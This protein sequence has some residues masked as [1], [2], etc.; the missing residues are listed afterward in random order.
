[1]D[2]DYLTLCT[3]VVQEVEFPTGYIP[4]KLVRLAL[5]TKESFTQQHITESI[6][7]DYD[8]KNK[9]SL[10]IIEILNKIQRKAYYLENL[11]KVSMTKIAEACSNVSIRK[12]YPSLE[13][14]LA[15]A[16]EL[17][18]MGNAS[19][20]FPYFLNE[21]EVSITKEAASLMTSYWRQRH[22]LDGKQI[23]SIC[24]VLNQIQDIILSL[25]ISNNTFNSPVKIINQTESAMM[26]STN[27]IGTVV[28]SYVSPSP[29]EQQAT[30]ETVDIDR[31]AYRRDNSAALITTS[32]VSI[33]KERM[34]FHLEESDQY[35]D[36]SSKIGEV[37]RKLFPEE[38]SHADK[39]IPIDETTK[40]KPLLR[41]NPV[42][43]KMQFIKLMK[44]QLNNKQIRDCKYA[45]VNGLKYINNS[46]S[47][48]SLLLNDEKLSNNQIF[49][50]GLASLPNSSKA[51]HI[52]DAETI[53]N[54]RNNFSSFVCESIGDKD[55]GVLVF[56]DRESH[57][58]AQTYLLD[59]SRTPVFCPTLG[60]PDKNSEILDTPIDANDKFLFIYVIESDCHLVAYL[61]KWFINSRSTNKCLPIVYVLPTLQAGIGN[62]RYLI[63]QFAE[64]KLINHEW[65]YM[66][67]DSVGAIFTK[68]SKREN[69]C[70][71]ITL[72][73]ALELLK[74]RA[75]EFATSTDNEVTVIGTVKATSARP[76]CVDCYFP[77]FRFPSS[78]ILLNVRVC[79]KYSLY[80]DPL[81]RV[82]ED[83]CFSMRSVFKN[84]LVLVDKHFA[85][86]KKQFHSGGSTNDKFMKVKNT[87]STF[88]APPSFA[89]TFENA[90]SSESIQLREEQVQAYFPDEFDNISRKC[91]VVSSD[92][93]LWFS[94]FGECITR[95]K[96]NSPS[97]IG[98]VY[99]RGSQQVH[100]A[101]HEPPMIFLQERLFTTLD[102]KHGL[103]SVN[104]IDHQCALVVS[105]FG[106]K[107]VVDIRCRP[108]ITVCHSYM[109]KQPHSVLNSEYIDAQIISD[110]QYLVLRKSGE[111]RL[112]D[113]RNSSEAI[114]KH[115]SI[116]ENQ[117]K[118][119]G[120]YTVNRYPMLHVIQNSTTAQSHVM[121]SYCN[122]N[123]E[124]FGAT[125]MNWETGEQL[126]KDYAFEFNHRP[127]PVLDKRQN[128]CMLSLPTSNRPGKM[129]GQI[130][131][132]AQPSTIVEINT[133]NVFSQ[134][135]IMRWSPFDSSSFLT[136]TSD[137]DI[138]TAKAFANIVVSYDY[139]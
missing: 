60:R 87:F 14:L 101:S 109:L 134:N 17:C 19:R 131:S 18:W 42:M 32:V 33:S 104:A 28:A 29:N 46:K 95:I 4:D 116:F 51:T 84:V 113:I 37:S 99:R 82:A 88:I 12:G 44:K 97:E 11:N 31:H 83:I 24:K 57:V 22:Q 65:I 40:E 128:I 6:R 106:N 45:V 122:R 111:V 16:L 53:N 2:L 74:Q 114:V 15:I 130:W 123:G 50:D 125:L 138:Y 70:E 102:A 77:S 132:S 69:G 76:T 8:L 124:S 25:N 127:V 89:L 36:I 58:L 137:D 107:R 93:K 30:S 20:K 80:Y 94:K 71:N 59:S 73:P 63:Q 64:L 23:N 105:N 5:S 129:T 34:K 118:Q 100:I 41:I 10:Q 39:P 112:Y 9:K 136:V 3:L 52:T 91:G 43:N 72:L 139:M 7:D 49:L 13:K 115:T 126:P 98:F 92:G 66:V 35:H 103:V 54:I 96:S 47:N 67:D 90:L 120:A 110:C 55:G 117:C 1:M 86:M 68:P 62:T 119:H 79:K 81:H 26:L 61:Q 27:Q 135:K 38:D 48:H 56:K 133:T 21:E 108:D 121:V 85:H 78:L 75:I